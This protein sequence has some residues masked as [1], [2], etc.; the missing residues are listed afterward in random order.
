MDRRREIEEELVRG[1][2]ASYVEVVDESHLH[3]GHEGARA[4][5]GH[6]RA[7]IVSSHFIG[8]S[9]VQAQRL[10]YR[11]LAEQMEGAIHALSMTTLTPDQWSGGAAG[12]GDRDGSAA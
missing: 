11:I 6:F 7:T 3:A 9:R 12:P 1:L 10:V 4:G 5:G 8:L 2:E